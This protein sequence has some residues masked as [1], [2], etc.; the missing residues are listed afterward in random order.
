MTYHISLPSWLKKALLIISLPTI[1]I[2]YLIL[3]KPYANCELTIVSITIPGLP[4]ELDGLKIGHLSDIH[5]GNYKN[6]KELEA[7]IQLLNSQKPDIVFITGDLIEHHVEE[8]AEYAPTLRKIEA[9]EGIYSCFGNHEYGPT[10]L[11]VARDPQRCEAIK[12]WQ[13][14]FGWK[15][16]LNEHTF[17]KRKG[18]KIAIIGVENYSTGSFPSYGDLAKASKGTEQAALR[19]LLSHDPSHWEAE[20]VRAEPAIDVMFAGHTHGI[21]YKFTR[22]RKGAKSLHI[23]PQYKGLYQKNNRYL[24]VHGAF[25]NS[26]KLGKLFRK[27]EVAIITLRR[28]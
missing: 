27:R 13:E 21:K 18:K 19:L 10:H 23:Y 25:G 4:Q 6:K 8:L 7:G 22:A 5:C 17:L 28:G 12:A 26:K 3:Q 24:Y 1:L 16:L 9:K 14:A 15:V 2:G 20:V 11:H